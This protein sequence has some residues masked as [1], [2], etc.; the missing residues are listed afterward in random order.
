MT[1]QSMHDDPNAPSRRDFL[2]VCTGAFGAV[3]GATAMWPLIDQLN[4]NS[5]T[6]TGSIFVD[7][8][9]IEPG[10]AVTVAW[11]G[12]PIVIR[13]RTPAEIV[14][15]NSVAVD[16][17][18]DPYARN[19]ASSVQAPAT[20][21]NRTLAGRPEWLVVVGVCTHLGCKLK[22]KAEV[23]R[24]DLGDGW[25]C[26]CHAAHF[27]LSGRVRG[28]PAL[29]NLPVPPYRFIASNRIEIGRI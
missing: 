8:A 18:P 19:I 11:R 26:P 23:G 17:L 6:A 24:N 1:A 2:Y 13:H 5:G 7:L 16:D 20:D 9:P 3:G 29:T 27:D 15:V 12:Q 14:R 21:A 22:T 25:F 28:G 10:Q 4:P